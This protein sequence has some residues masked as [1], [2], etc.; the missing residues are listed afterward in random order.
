[1][2]ELAENRRRIPLKPLKISVHGKITASS[3]LFTTGMSG[4]ESVILVLFVMHLYAEVVGEG[5]HQPAHVGQD[6]RDPEKVVE[7]GEG[8]SAKAGHQGE[9]TAGKFKK[10]FSLIYCLRFEKK[11]R[12]NTNIAI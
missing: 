2:H 1:M 12:D 5:T 9:E 3:Q 4:R 6:E 7:S 8:T 11:N 10:K